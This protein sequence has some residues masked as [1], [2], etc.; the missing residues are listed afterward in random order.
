MMAYIGYFII[1]VTVGL[2]VAILLADLR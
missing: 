2:L 1:L